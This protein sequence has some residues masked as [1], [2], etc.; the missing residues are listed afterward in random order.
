MLYEPEW[1][2]RENSRKDILLAD[3]PTDSYNSRKYWQI[4]WQ[5]A[6]GKTWQI[7]FTKSFSIQMRFRGDSV[8]TQQVTNTVRRFLYSNS[9]WH[10]R[11]CAARNFTFWQWKRKVTFQSWKNFIK[12]KTSGGIG[13]FFFLVFGGIEVKSICQLIW[14]E[15]C[16]TAVFFLS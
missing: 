12:H 11:F 2:Y 15:N 13:Q 6:G 8:Q 10:C 16:L 4:D 14:T 1:H 3:R 9:V 7:T 5:Q